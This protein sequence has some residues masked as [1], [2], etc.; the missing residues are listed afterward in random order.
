MAE[1]VTDL[2]LIAFDAEDMAVVSAHLQDALVQRAA[3]TWL[4]AQKR[5]ALFVARFDWSA[6]EQGRKERVGAG[7]RFE[8][9]LKVTETGLREVAADAELNLLAIRFEETDPPAGAVILLFSGGAAVRLEVECLEAELRDIGPRLQ[10]TEC[11][12]HLLTGV[13]DIA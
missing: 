12:G 5:F 6:F 3:M 8:R 11:P 13:A 2:A 1:T 10:V 9:A 7:L 4:P